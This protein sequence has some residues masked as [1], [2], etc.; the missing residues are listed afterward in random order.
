MFNK[1]Y[2]NKFNERKSLELMDAALQDNAHA[3]DS[4]VKAGANINYV[5]EFGDTAL[6]QAALQGHT[7]TLKKLLSYLTARYSKNRALILASGAG[8]SD[9]I[10][11]LLKAGAEVNT[12]MKNFHTPLFQAIKHNNIKALQR[13]LATACID[14]NQEDHE[15]IIPILLAAKNGRLAMLKL[16]VSHGAN[17]TIKNAEGRTALDM[18]I[19]NKT[20]IT[21]NNLDFIL[22]LIVGS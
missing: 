4:L 11:I 16:L 9:I 22:N 7:E 5:D 19:K 20:S 18:A 10:D 14:V 13:L 8:H 3:I 12:Y 2:E 6:C 15:G 1:S 17:I 21:F